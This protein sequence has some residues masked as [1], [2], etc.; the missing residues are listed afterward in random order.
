MRRE[1]NTSSL[2]INRSIQGVF[3]YL[4]EN[5]GVKDVQF[6]EMV[7]LDSDS[8]RQLSSDALSLFLLGSALRFPN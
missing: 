4:V 2:T 6:E 5:L 8:L 3:T 1:K 7:S